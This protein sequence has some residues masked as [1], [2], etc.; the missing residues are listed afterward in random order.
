[1]RVDLRIYV[2]PTEIEMDYKI[3]NTPL[4][5]KKPG[6]VV[7]FYES[8]FSEED[9]DDIYDLLNKAFIGNEKT[10]NRRSA[11]PLGDDG[12]VYEI[13]FGGYKGIPVRYSRRPSKPWNT[14]PVVV[15]LKEIVEELTGQKYNVC[16][17]LKYP[18]GKV[19]MQA[20]R[21]REMITGSKDE[22]VSSK[23][24]SGLSFGVSRKL[25]LSPTRYIRQQVDP[26]KL[27]LKSGSLYVM[28]PP[29][30]NF[31]T[32][33]IEK[34]ETI[35]DARISITFRDYPKPTNP[36]SLLPLPTIQDKVRERCIEITKKKERCKNN[37][38]MYLNI[39]GDIRNEQRYS[40]TNIPP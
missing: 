22:V 10:G 37:A 32:H 3:D 21:D 27:D 16:I 39:V 4:K 18:N 35:T 6:L 8:L 31:W 29:T 28:H 40:G 15:K 7:D 38:T 33:A 25:V 14:I 34:D 23:I 20:H 13:K 1:L 17:I 5:Y 9:S 26:I 11:I 2:K 24:I 19:G 30:N 36:L 12:I